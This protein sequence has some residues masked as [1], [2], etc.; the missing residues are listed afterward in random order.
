[1]FNQNTKGAQFSQNF[2]YAALHKKLTNDFG[3][4]LIKSVQL[5]STV[6]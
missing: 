1:M 3:L 4:L 2:F 6:F 5:T